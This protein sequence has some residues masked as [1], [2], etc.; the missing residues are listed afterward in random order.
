MAADYEE[1]RVSAWIGH[2]VE[3]EGRITSGQDLRI[4]GK[5]QGTI[6][7]GDHSVIVGQ[8]AT[9]TADLVARAILIS[10]TVIGDV[11]ASERVELKAGASVAGD[12]TT[13]HLMMADGAIVNGTIDAAGASRL[14]NR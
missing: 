3:I 8:S 13:P 2:G 4:D 7:V 10:G 1:R 11:T 5:V 9:I 6:E 14:L 12:I